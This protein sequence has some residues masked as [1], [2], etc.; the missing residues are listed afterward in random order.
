MFIVPGL[1]TPLDL[2]GRTTAIFYLKSAVKSVQAIKML[3]L[4]IC[5]SMLPSP[6]FSLFLDH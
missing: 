6:V 1:S 3:T 2:G 5:I 4:D